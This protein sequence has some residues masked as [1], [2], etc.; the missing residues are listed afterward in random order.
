M[1]LVDVDDLELEVDRR[2][3][4]KRSQEVKQRVAIFTAAHGDHD[5]VSLLDHGKVR[6]RPGNGLREPLRRSR[7]RSPV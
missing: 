3:L 7:H 4:L 6:D 1:A 5:A 2:L